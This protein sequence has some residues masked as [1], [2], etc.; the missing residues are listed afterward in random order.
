MPLRLK[1]LGSRYKTLN[2]IEISKKSLSDNFDYFSS[3]NPASKVC[4][5]L[6]S[7]AYGHGLCLIG[8]FVDRQLRPEFV[9]VDSLYEAYGLYKAGLKTKILI[10]GYTFPENFKF[11]KINFRI[12]LFDL[13][14]LK[15]L[16]KYQPEAKVHLKIDTG[17][18][19]L[20]IK[21]N[22][23]EVFA[24]EL[25]K[26]KH[27]KIEG[28]YSHLAD[29]DNHQSQEFSLKQIERFKKAIKFFEE[30]GFN[31]KYKHIC[32]TAGSVLFNDPVFNLTRLG[33]GFYGISP[34]SEGSALNKG[35]SSKIS[36]SLRLLTHVAAI[37]KVKKGEE[38]GYN[39]SF[40][41]DVDM[42]LAI[43]PI[44]YYDGI[45][46]RF[47]GKGKVLI[48]D[49]LCSVIGKVCMNIT[50]VDATKVNNLKVGEKVIIF[51]DSKD[52]P[53]SVKA[54]SLSAGKSPYETLVN[55]S[56]TT[57]RELC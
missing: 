34:F 17:M 37:K 45:D 8:R 36:P 20:G 13:E 42:K 16:A 19:R 47:G 44:G 21:E 31:F 56:E 51:S 30:K 3:L 4:P 41:A 27:L 9:C 40:K 24:R 26:V 32:A 39:L 6:K 18:N 11:K 33:I 50:M 15:V 48:K 14:T 7:N 43:L 29:A 35:L 10:M 25:K 1:S 22:E 55:L 5:V 54:A 12:P 57:R 46:R 28:I 23:F 49:K 52:S 53:V 38:I 2:L